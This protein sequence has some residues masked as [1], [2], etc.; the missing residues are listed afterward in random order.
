MLGMT[1]IHRL[2]NKIGVLIRIL[3]IISTIG[4]FSACAKEAFLRMIFPANEEFKSGNPPLKSLLQLPGK[5]MKHPLG[6]RK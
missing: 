4:H 6:E 2:P 5:S 3:W 1:P